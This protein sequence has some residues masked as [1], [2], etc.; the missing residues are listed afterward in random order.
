MHFV[1]PNLVFEM[2]KRGLS[3]KDIASILGIS[4]HAAY[5]RMRG[6]VGWKLYE[7]IKLCQ[8]FG[9]N[10]TAWLFRCDVAMSNCNY[11]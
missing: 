3:Y 7:T 4:E 11:Q 2:N 6:L 10:D 5:R 8:H 1:Y 9:V